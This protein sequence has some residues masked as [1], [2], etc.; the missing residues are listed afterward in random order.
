[1][2]SM[3]EKDNV[4]HPDHY[5]EYGLESLEAIKGSMSHL[6]YMGFLKGN[7]LKYLYRYRLKGRAK[8]DLEKARFYLTEMINEIILDVEVK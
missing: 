7:S 2:S 8:E 5:R 6:E 4:N 1:M 3:Q